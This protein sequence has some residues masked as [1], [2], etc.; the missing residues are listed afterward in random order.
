MTFSSYLWLLRNRERKQVFIVGC[1]AKFPQGGNFQSKF[2]KM[3]GAVTHDPNHG[4]LRYS[5]NSHQQIEFVKS[6]IGPTRFIFFL[7]FSVWRR[8]SENIG[9]FSS[10][11][12]HPFPSIASHLLLLQLLAIKSPLFTSLLFL[13]LA[14]HTTIFIFKI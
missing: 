3:S 14:Q 11:T 12:S 5:T 4:N 6:G 2:M 10:N 8:P 7:E 9:H 13:L 1:G